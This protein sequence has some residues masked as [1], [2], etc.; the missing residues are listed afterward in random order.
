MNKIFN[1]FLAV[2][3]KNYIYGTTAEVSF[4]FEQGSSSHA[5]HTFKLKR[6]FFFIK[7]KFMK[8]INP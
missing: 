4:N 7:V 3:R 8:L 5:K 6:F 2:A 1:N